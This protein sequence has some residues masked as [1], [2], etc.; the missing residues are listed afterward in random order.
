MGRL[1]RKSEWQLHDVNLPS[2]NCLVYAQIRVLHFQYTLLTEIVNFACSV[3]LSGDKTSVQIN[4]YVQ[5]RTGIC[6]CSDAEATIHFGMV[7]LGICILK[8]GL[9]RNKIFTSP[10]KFITGEVLLGEYCEV[11]ISLFRSLTL[12]L[13]STH[14]QTDSFLIFILLYSCVQTMWHDHAFQ[15]MAM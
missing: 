4:L 2:E 12:W 13:G 11:Y 7:V 1:L 3:W 10:H 6:K 5:S 15:W 14:M 9:Y 8:F